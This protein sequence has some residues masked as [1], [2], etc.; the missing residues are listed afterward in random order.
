[1][2]L[3]GIINSRST[4]PCGWPATLWIYLPEARSSQR[5]KVDPFKSF[6][7]EGFKTGQCIKKA[8]KSDPK[9]GLSGVGT[10]N[11]LGESKHSEMKLLY[12]KK[13]HLL[14]QLP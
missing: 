2:T 9:Q 3:A 14:S 11:Q 1:M 4:N 12:L 7:S 8:K 5:S 6:L 10:Y 13:G